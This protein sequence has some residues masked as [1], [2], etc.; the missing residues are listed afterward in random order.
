MTRVGSETRI[1]VFERE[2]KLHAL[3][4]A[5]T[6]IGFILY[7]LKYISVLSS[8]YFQVS[9]VVSSL[10]V[11]GLKFC[12]WSCSEEHVNSEGLNKEHERSSVNPM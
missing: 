7:R 5:A 4:R 11:L 12:S 10:E 3:D 8:R 2:K 9:Q 1:P 6:V